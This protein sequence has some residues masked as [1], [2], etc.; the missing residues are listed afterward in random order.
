MEMEQ[1]Y[2][3]QRRGFGF[4]LAWISGMCNMMVQVARIGKLWKIGL[5]KI[6]ALIKKLKKNFWRVN[7]ICYIKPTNDDVPS[8]VDCT[9]NIVD[10]KV[11]DCYS[12]ILKCW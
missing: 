8:R 3:G 9:I 10:H 11:W 2:S 5:K 6:N 1:N 4:A 12:A 7:H